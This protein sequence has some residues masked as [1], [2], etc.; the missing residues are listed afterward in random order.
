MHQNIVSLDVSVHQAF[1]VEVGNTFDDLEQNTGD[2]LFVFDS[3]LALV[4]YDLSQ[5]PASAQRHH[6]PQLLFVDEAGVVSQDVGVHAVADDRDLFVLFLHGILTIE[7]FK[8][9]YL[10]G[11][12]FLVSR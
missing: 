5:C 2:Y 6:N 11:N 4:I 12:L 1:G 7:Q 8:G 9:N 10:D 3:L